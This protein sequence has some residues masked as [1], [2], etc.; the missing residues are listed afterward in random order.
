LSDRVADKFVAVAVF[1]CKRYE[2]IAAAYMPRVYGYVLVGV[3]W[4]VAPG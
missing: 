4:V 1:A 3:A 2:Q